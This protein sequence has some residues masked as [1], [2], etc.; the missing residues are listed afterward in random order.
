[1]TKERLKE[2]ILE[3]ESCHNEAQRELG[4]QSK[5]FED[6]KLF[7]KAFILGD[8]IEKLKCLLDLM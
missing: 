3:L 7:L 5:G 4:D 2:V 1:M 6:A 8:A